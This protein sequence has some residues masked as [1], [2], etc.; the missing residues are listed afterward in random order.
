MRHWSPAADAKLR[1][2]YATM[3]WPQLCFQLKRSE[4]AIRQRARKLG[5]ELREFWTAAEIRVL[6][7]RYRNEATEAIARD[8][9]REREA[10]Y[11]KANALG[12]HKTKKFMASEAYKAPLRA[13]ALTNP[14]VRAGRFQKGHVPANKGVRRPGYAVGRMATTQF[15]KGRPTS[16]ARNYVAIGTEKYDVKRKT[17]VRKITDDPKVFPSMRWRPVHVLVWEAVHGPVP[18]GH[19]VIFKKGHKTLVSAEITVDRLELV[20]LAENMRR[21]S[22]H[23][24]YP[25]EVGLAI[26]AKAV[27]T[28]AINRSQRDAQR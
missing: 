16:E 27:L 1:K 17:T 23:N 10:V 15:K 19:I 6:R 22:F 7:K 26:Q 9:G 14:R 3:P 2:H 5:L 25:K 24:N 13:N 28:R 20:T 11:A 21:N 18:D 12:L 8:L 4:S